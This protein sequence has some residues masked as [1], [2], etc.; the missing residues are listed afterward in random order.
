MVLLDRL[1]RNDKSYT[2]LVFYE[3]D[4]VRTDNFLD[5]VTAI[6]TN[7][8]VKTV[9]F[10]DCANPKWSSK[11]V[12]LLFSAIARLPNLKYMSIARTTVT[13]QS[14]AVVAEKSVQLQEL[15]VW[16]SK[17]V[18]S[19]DDVRLF[20]EALRDSRL[21]ALY[22]KRVTFGG[23]GQLDPFF[24]ACQES[25]TV[26]QLDQVQWTEGAVSDDVFRLLHTTKLVELAIANLSLHDTQLCAIAESLRHNKS[27][28]SFI[29]RNI[30]ICNKAAGQL[31]DAL[32]VNDRLHRLCLNKCSLSDVAA[33]TL[34]KMLLCNSTL[35]ALELSNNDI[36]NQGAMDLADALLHSCIQQLELQ[37]NPR[38]GAAGIGALV[39][40]AE[41]SETLETM[42]L[43]TMSRQSS[44]LNQLDI[45]RKID[46][47]M[48]LNARTRDP[49]HIS[50]KRRKVWC[51]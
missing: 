48:N 2:E 21:A 32:V 29:L 22:L 1:R 13:L 43:Y 8:H 12:K 17:L 33:T 35:T 20:A 41:A 11:Q 24:A 4:F 30:T 28:K 16:E 3:S 31:A 49:A 5:L 9:H 40:L 25:L 36:G 26:F 47:C 42:K 44:T 7:T 18:A 51:E 38:I 15:D 14:L 23:D 10:H 46:S 19:E 39:Q 50:G 27:L 34:A 6:L 37:G 45:Q